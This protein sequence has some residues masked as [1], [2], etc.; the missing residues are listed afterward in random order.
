MTGLHPKKELFATE[1]LRTGAMKASAIAAGYSPKSA[2]AAATR[3]LKDPYVVEFLDAAR[4]RSLAVAQYGASQAMRELE[5]GMRF[6]RETKNAT[7]LARLIELRMK[8]AGL[9]VDRSDVRML[10]GF[11][12]EIAGI[13]DGAGEVAAAPVVSAAAAFAASI[14]DP[15]A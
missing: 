4:E 7:A 9:L 3:L 6:A 2:S 11:R 8:H 5:D 12:I 10:G 14:A 13:G 15:F 1:Y